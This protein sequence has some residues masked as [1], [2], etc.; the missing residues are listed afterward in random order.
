MSV[1]AVEEKPK[2]KPIIYDIRI[3]QKCQRCGKDYWRVKRSF[4]ICQ[5]GMKCWLIKTTDG[6]D[7]VYRYHQAD[8]PPPGAVVT[9][10]NGDSFIRPG[11]KATERPFL[12][13]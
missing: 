12:S 5:C 10:E 6:A 11:K 13:V 7:T 2:A 8:Y 9:G 1:V 4:K 3:G